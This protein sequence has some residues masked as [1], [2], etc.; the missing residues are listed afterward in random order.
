MN[1]KMMLA[2]LLVLGIVGLASTAH[3]A[4]SQ[5]RPQLSPFAI[6]R[7]EITVVGDVTELQ[8]SSIMSGGISAADA[9]RAARGQ[10]S[11]GSGPITVLRG[12][13]AQ[14]VDSEVKPVFIVVAAGGAIPFDGPP[15][16]DVLRQPVRVTGVIV[17]AATG[18]FLRG[19]MFT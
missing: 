3:G 11:L 17:D 16:T 8:D 4:Q 19:F 1:R 2:L 18:E 13:A 10:V 5:S 12:E 6:A 9:V 14:F 15:G 7:A